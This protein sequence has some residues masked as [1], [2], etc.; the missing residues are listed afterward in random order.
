MIQRYTAYPFLPRSAEEIARSILVPQS[1]TPPADPEGNPWAT[2][3]KP[4]GS[5]SAIHFI[6]HSLTCPRHWIFTP[7]IQSVL[8]QKDI[9]FH[10]HVMENMADKLLQR[11]TGQA[12]PVVLYITNCHPQKAS[13]SSMLSSEAAQS[14]CRSTQDISFHES[15]WL[16]GRWS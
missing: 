9:P 1:R 5:E 4:K 11:A 3:P 15:L 16:V 13:S 2:T 6:L 14:R 8:Y 12:V 7:A 10:I